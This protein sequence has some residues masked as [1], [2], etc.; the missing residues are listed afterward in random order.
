MHRA[1]N[2]REREREMKQGGWLFNT[3]RTNLKL[4]G[5]RPRAEMTMIASRGRRGKE[6][7]G[8]HEISRSARG[9]EV[10]WREEEAAWVEVGGKRSGSSTGKQV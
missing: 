7:R 10:I 2:K 5:G 1:N 9:L 6:R 3:T 8:T 4:A